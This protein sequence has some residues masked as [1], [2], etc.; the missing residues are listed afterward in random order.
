ML[1]Y[2]YSERACLEM[3]RSFIRFSFIY[4]ENI[5]FFA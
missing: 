4:R 5:I 2:Y 1:Y 3:Q